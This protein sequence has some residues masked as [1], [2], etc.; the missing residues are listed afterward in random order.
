MKI[1]YDPAKRALTLKERGLDFQDAVLVFA[2]RTAT[3]PDQRKDY[4]EERF[5]TAGHLRQRLVVLV[6][7]HRGNTRRIIS[8]RYGHAKEA[9]AWAAHLD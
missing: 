7:T 6:W 3:V 5:I 9:E 8:M 4:G 1:S 2:G